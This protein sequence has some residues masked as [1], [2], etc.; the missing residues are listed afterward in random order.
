LPTPKIL[1]PE[2]ISSLAERSGINI[3]EI[4][5]LF[6]RKIEVFRKPGS[7]QEAFRRFRESPDRS[8]E[9]M[10]TFV[11]CL[12]L[13]FKIDR[14]KLFFLESRKKTAISDSWSS[15]RLIKS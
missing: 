1:T 11:H 5:G 14:R 6:N 12:G 3:G 4:A 8:S 13:A 15:Q 7:F 10:I 9:R 2:E